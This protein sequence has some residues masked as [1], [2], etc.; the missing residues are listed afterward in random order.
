[1]TD[2]L[3]TA[4][5]T[6]LPQVEAVK[7][8]G[9][10]LRASPG[11]LAVRPGFRVVGGRLTQE[12]A[13]VVTV[14]RKRP[15]RELDPSAVLPTRVGGVAVDVLQ[16]EPAALAAGAPRG[17]DNWDWL[18]HP[19]EAEAAPEIGYRPPSG[20]RLEPV[21]ADA[22]LCHVSPDTGW[23]TLE[24]FLK[25]ARERLTVA[26]YDFY[27]DHIVDALA[28]LGETAPA[29]SLSLILQAD[30]PREHEVVDR[31]RQAWG[32]RLD[33]TPA[34]VSG[35]RR[36]FASSYHTKVVVRD[37]QAF[38][39]SSGNFSGTSQPV[40]PPGAEKTLYAL[41]N[42][43]WHVVVTDAA[44]A[45]T[46]E[47]FIRHDMAQA[48]EALQG[49]APEAAPELPDLLVPES[50]LFLPE[51]AVEQPHP[52]A[53]EEFHGVRV[54]PLMTPDNYTDAAVALIES[55]QESLYL[56]YSYIRIPKYA[57]GFRRIIDAVTG[58]IEAG[59]DVRIIVGRNQA[60]G[61]TQ[62]LQAKGWSLR[63]F[64]YQTSK[65]HNKGVLVDGRVA[66]VGSQNWSGE[67][68]Q[69]NRDASLVFRSEPIARYY[70]EVFR[71]DWDN[72]TRDPSLPEVTPVVAE[73]AHTPV[74]MVRIPWR[75]WYED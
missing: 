50:A 44:L 55:A 69:F 48:R 20:V 64:R 43:E 9:G 25:G 52:F 23:A 42:R 73:S 8:H 24:P 3:R 37:G 57:D 33:Y 4:P 59:V 66:V 38:W 1:M 7:R 18:L 47:A 27:A 35:P 54:E 2:L 21:E 75:A 16:E 17:V 29:L 62:A 22:V 5:S 68:T 13:V 11:V 63:H 60:V 53:P 49:G 31:L 74:G 15:L 56:Q 65:V 45:A 28:S 46:F 32:N 6:P 19:A 67:G 14:A 39:L 30:Q 41:G 40:V 71:F 34:V 61:D 12:P 36:V 72:L 10:A 26:M 58:R 70:H 51:A